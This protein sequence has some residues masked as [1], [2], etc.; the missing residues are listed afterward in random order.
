MRSPKLGY[1]TL[2]RVLRNHAFTQGL[3]DTQVSKLVSLATEVSF[4]ENEVILM[5]GSPSQ[6]MY[7]VVSGSVSIELHAA[8]F[9]VSVQALG[10]GE[11]FGWSAL[12]ED[13]GSLFQVRAREE[14]TTICLDGPDLARL[15]R[16]DTELGSEIL[17]RAL[18]I[19]ACRV[20]A[21]E[22]KFAEMCGIRVH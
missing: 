21:T 11:A 13:R 3:D 14:T 8:S 10:P 15:G 20:Q 5:D 4:A 9:T 2:D 12:L 6:A 17:R 16:S 1:L 22:A 18:Q 19:A 7:L